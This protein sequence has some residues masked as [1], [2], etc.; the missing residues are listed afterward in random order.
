VTIRPLARLV[1]LH[2]ALGHPLRLRL[3]AMLREGPL[4][5]CQMTGVVRRAA[6]TVSE[7]L[8][9]LRKAGAVQERKDGRWVEYRLADDPVARAALEAAWPELADDPDVRA[10]AMVLKELRPVPLEE[11]CRVNLD[12][13][14]VGRRRL[15]NA[16]AR[17]ADLRDR[18]G[19]GR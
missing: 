12:L 8:S 3:V 6:S 11:I 13:T 15:T 5:V 18:E 16:V 1:D 7:H 17:A 9:E 4:C 2:K 10:D 19:V 14:R